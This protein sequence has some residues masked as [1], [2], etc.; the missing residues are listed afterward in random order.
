MS[1]TESSSAICK[2]DAFTEDVLTLKNLQ[3]MNGSL[4]SY[5][6][7]GELPRSRLPEG[8]IAAGTKGRISRSPL[9]PQNHMIQTNHYVYQKLQTFGGRRVCKIIFVLEICILGNTSKYPKL[10]GLSYV[11]LKSSL[12][13]KPPGMVRSFLLF[14][15]YELHF[16]HRRSHK[17]NMSPGQ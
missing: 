1:N 11:R 6:R 15:R 16:Y 13:Q 9:G 17:V 7:K 12:F 3:K 10:V 4:W 2:S 14:C 8:W 5:M